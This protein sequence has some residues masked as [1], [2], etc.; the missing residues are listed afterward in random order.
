MQSPNG[1]H[2][3]AS[4]A[5]QGAETLSPEPPCPA[6]GMSLPLLTFVIDAREREEARG[7]A[8]E[9]ET[10][11]RPPGAA[12]WRRPPE[13]LGEWG[14]H[15]STVHSVAES[16]GADKPKLQGSCSRSPRSPAL[17]SERVLS[18]Q[19]STR[20]ADK[21]AHTELGQLGRRQLSLLC[22]CCVTLG[23]EGCLGGAFGQRP[24]GVNLTQAAFLNC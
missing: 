15:A 16:P 5:H 6:H 21:K 9:E 11:E 23:T 14:R 24:L 1:P 18:S 7:D 10:K 19:A 2:C 3:G 22:F 13:W 17:F 4:P 12:E 8:E 20:D